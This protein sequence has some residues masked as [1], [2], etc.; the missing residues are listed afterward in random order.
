[1]IIIAVFRKILPRK[2]FKYSGI[3]GIR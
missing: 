3:R 1:M 2:I